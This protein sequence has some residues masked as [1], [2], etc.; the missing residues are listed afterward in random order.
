MN[1]NQA[2]PG[3]SSGPSA[4]RLIF[5]YE[6]DDIRLIS[7]QRVNVVAPASEP[8]EGDLER[9]AG[10]WLEVRD[11]AGQALRRQLMQDP[12][13]HDVEVFADDPDRSVARIPLERP[14][15]VFAVLIPEIEEADHVALIGTPL[16][17]RPALARAREIARFSLADEPEGGGEAR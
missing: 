2:T 8:P 6:G 11:E 5:S 17:E 12:I 10:F 9:R 16:E 15:G 4:V 7:R 3:R 1:E 14:S 13:R